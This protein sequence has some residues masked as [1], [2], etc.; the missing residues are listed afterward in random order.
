MV[1]LFIRSDYDEISRRKICHYYC[2]RKCGKRL[3][4]ED[5]TVDNY[6]SW[7]KEEKG[8]KCN[9]LLQ[10]SLPEPDSEPY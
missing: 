8:P 4:K 7:L 1:H 5:I 2:C 10:S 3:S 9:G 6:K